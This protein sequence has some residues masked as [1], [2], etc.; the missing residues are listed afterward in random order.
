MSYESRIKF[1]VSLNEAISVKTSRGCTRNFRIYRCHCKGYVYEAVL[2]SKLTCQL[3]SFFVQNFVQTTS[4]LCKTTTTLG[5]TTSTLYKERRQFCM[6]NVHTLYEQRQHCTNNDNFVRT[7]STPL[8]EQRQLCTNND[9]FVRTTSTL[10]EQRQLCTNNVNIVRTTTTLY[11]Q[12]P[13]LSEQRREII[14]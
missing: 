5:K 8:Y 3:S 13:H 9:N 1:L 6:N 11:E 12:R 2:I 7:T 10:Y 4:T 14:D